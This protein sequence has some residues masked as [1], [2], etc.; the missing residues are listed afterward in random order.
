MPIPLPHDNPNGTATTPAASAKRS[1]RSH[2]RDPAKPAPSSVRHTRAVQRDR[3]K[4]PTG[5]PPDE[6]VTARLTELI[7]PATFSQ[8]AAYQ[9]MGLRERVLTLPVMVAFV[10]SLIWRQLAS[11]SEAVRVLREEGLL[12]TARVPVS[13]QAAAQRLSTF[14]AVLFAN[15]LHAVLPQVAARAQ[16]RHQ[17]PISAVLAQ[18][19]AAFGQVLA[20]DGST[21]DT[22][23]RKVGLLRGVTPAPLAGRM[24]GLLDVVTHLPREVWYEEEPTANDHRF[25]DRVLAALP[26][27]ALLLFDRGF[28]AYYR[29]DQLTDHGQFFITRPQATSAFQVERVLRQETDGQDTLRDQVGRLGTAQ[30]RAIHAVRLVELTYRGKRYRSLTNV[31]DPTRLSAEAVVAL[32][33]Q[34]WRIEDAFNV[35]KRLLGLAYF[36]VGSHNGVLVQVWATWLLYAVLVDLTDA[37]ADALHQPLQ[38]LSLEMVYRGLYHFTQAFH[39]GQADDPVAYLASKAHDLGLLKRPRPTRSSPAHLVALTR[40]QA[41]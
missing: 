38:A 33:W 30:T 26:V 25:W 2:R 4:R 9:A 13:Q 18:A 36:Y 22:L 20:V 8:V 35:V 12:W 17:R 21:L 24:A 41:P 14:P 23:L 37:V 29:F 32:Y 40:P 10:L 1:S 19:Q 28:L 34:R 5:A 7:S 15:V 27:G 16:A 3:T 39:R 6:Q 11:V 31:L